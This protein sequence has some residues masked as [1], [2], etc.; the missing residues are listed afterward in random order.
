MLN[1][2]DQSYLAQGL[3]RMFIRLAVQCVDSKALSFMDKQKA[4][5]RGLICFSGL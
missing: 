4:A 1:I 2:K 3:S 5:L